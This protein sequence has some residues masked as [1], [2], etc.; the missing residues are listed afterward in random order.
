MIMTILTEGL[1]LASTDNIII[2]AYNNFDQ[3][4]V[5][6]QENINQFINDLFSRKIRKCSS[7]LERDAYINW[8]SV[9]MFNLRKAE[10]IF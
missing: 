8:Q 9:A 4:L 5:L 6:L 7:K 3:S 1:I 2:P 10:Q